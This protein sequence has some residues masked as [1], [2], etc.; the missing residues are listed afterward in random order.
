MR[1]AACL[2]ALLTTSGAWA[3]GTY[4]VAVDG[5]DSRSAQQAQNAA[6]PWRSINHA[7]SN[8][9][10]GST[11]I[12]GDGT[13]FEDPRFNTSGTAENYTRLMAQNPL[14]ARVVGSIAGYGV[15]HIV[16][17]G[18][19]VTNPDNRLGEA[20]GIA[21]YEGHHIVARGNEVYDCQGGG[22]AVD[23]S[24][25]VLIEKNVTYR[26]G[27]THPDQHS[28][29]S[30]FQ[31]TAGPADP[32]DS[33]TIGI[34]IRNNVSW[35]NE[36]R[37]PSAEFGRPTDGNGIIIDD[38]TN[39]YRGGPNYT[40]TTVVEN[41]LCYDNGGGGVHCYK[42]EN[43]IVRNNTTVGNATIVDPGGNISVVDSASVAV[44]NNIMSGDS[45][46]PTALQLSS[47]GVVWNF[48]L[49][50]GASAGVSN[51]P[52]TVYGDPRFL[53][54][55]YLLSGQSPAIDAGQTPNPPVFEEDIEG[56]TRVAGTAIDIGAD[57]FRVIVRRNSDSTA[58]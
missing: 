57:E 30:V 56:H 52:N 54:G 21:F 18:L 12:L 32:D 41:N 11:V 38:S 13:W 35:G 36:N 29:V 47:S 15:H 9:P 37:V 53:Q 3:Q 51:G 40:K 34:I 58:E 46:K 8:A 22:I 39:S 45:T 10:G 5:D 26:N 17:E 25:F 44:Y 42:S 20:K 2:L 28:G 4:F 50:E 16:V 19:K 49:L 14:Q 23:R 31:A 6:T 24:D 33:P 1:F 27:F 55:T 48:N 7:I 43:V